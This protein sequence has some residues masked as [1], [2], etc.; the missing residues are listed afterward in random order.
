MLLKQINFIRI[1]NK[2]RSRDGMLL[3]KVYK[4]VTHKYKVKCKNGHHW[5]VTGDKILQGRWCPV[6][7]KKARAESI[8]KFSIAHFQILAKKKSGLCLS[9]TYYS[10]KSRLEFRCKNGHKW[11]TSGAS[12]LSGSWC[13]VCAGVSKVALGTYQDLAAERGGKCLSTSVKNAREKLKWRCSI[14][15]TWLAQAGAVSSGGWCPVCLGR[16]KTIKDMRAIANINEGKCLS[17]AY[18]G[19]DRNLI[20]KCKYNHKWK[21]TPKSVSGLGSWCPTC[22]YVRVGDALRKYSLNDI[23]NIAKKRNGKFLN[24]SFKTV[25]EIGCFECEKGHTW[26]TTIASVLRG[27]WCAYCAGVGKYNIKDLKKKAK[28]N[29]GSL[30]TKNYKN[31]FALMTWKCKY[32]HIWN[33]ST[34]NILRG[35]WCPECN[36]GL[37]ERITRANFEQIFKKPFPSVRPEWLKSPRNI[38]MELDGYNEELGLAFEYQGLQHTEMTYHHKNTNSLNQRREYDKLKIK[39]C[40]KQNIKLIQVPQISTE[41]EIDNLKTFL[42]L[43]FKKNNV[44]LPKGVRNIKI[45]LNIAYDHD[46]LKKYREIA[47]KKKWQ[48][49]STSYLGANSRLGV[50]C[51]AGHE[52]KILPGNMIKRGCRICGLENRRQKHLSKLQNKLELLAKSKNG[53]LLKANFSR[54]KS[55]L[56]FICR[57]DHVWT[58]SDKSIASGAWCPKCAYVENGLSRKVNTLNKIKSLSIAKGGQCLST[59]YVDKNIKMNFK[60]IKKHEFQMSWWTFS[61]GG[62]CKEC[63]K[64]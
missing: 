19:Y 43:E 18:M 47:S 15:H 56:K 20:W 33:N 17:K 32:G 40:K 38:K 22:A 53:K 5:S 21:A 3:S 46:R 9:T 11:E 57:N 49:L 48:L 51:E 34:S 29:G 8:R 23:K 24:K 26:K 2:I 58:T 25:D 4:G 16:N 14:G 63:Y 64:K 59:V 44:K 45:N 31:S 28:E 36:R 27:S 6:C 1:N 39:I 55:T 12:I 61:H 10:P 7:A 54:N 35:Q 13:A 60:C 37:G 30:V 62:W 42:I 50:R 52:W 41:E